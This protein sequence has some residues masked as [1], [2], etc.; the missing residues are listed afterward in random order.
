MGNM[1]IEIIV[2][3][4]HQNKPGHLFENLRL[5]LH[6]RRRFHIVFR[7]APGNQGLGKFGGKAAS[8]VHA[9]IPRPLCQGNMIA[10]HGNPQG[11]VIQMEL[12]LVKIIPDKLPLSFFSWRLF[13]GF[14]RQLCIRFPNRP[15]IFTGTN[16]HLHF[17]LRRI[18]S[19]FHHQPLILRPLHFLNGG[20]PAQYVTA[21]VRKARRV[22]RISLL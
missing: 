19:A 21:P 22:G 14:R 9:K 13:P 16:R 11:L 3:I 10:V 4:V 18:P 17:R 8:A 2:R 5:K 1:K 20:F 6:A 15:F 7:H 12:R